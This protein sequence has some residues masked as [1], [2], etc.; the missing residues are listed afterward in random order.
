MVVAYGK[1]C[2]PLQGHRQAWKFIQVNHKKSSSF[3]LR[4]IIDRLWHVNSISS[5]NQT[6]DFA[7]HYPVLLSEVLHYFSA[8]RIRTFVDGT[9]G[10]GGHSEA[11]G[12]F[13]IM[14]LS[15]DVSNIEPFPCHFIK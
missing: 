3:L 14:K 6:D 10:A 7:V 5:G 8:C 4:G 2:L 12:L 11:V 13:V 15:F 9:V 1:W